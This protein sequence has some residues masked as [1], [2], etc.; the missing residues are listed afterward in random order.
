MDI[1]KSVFGDDYKYVFDG[2]PPTY[3]GF[4][5]NMLMDYLENYLTPTESYPCDE[6]Q[7]VSNAGDVEIY[8]LNSI[9]YEIITWNE[10]AEEHKNG[11]KEISEIII[12]E[13]VE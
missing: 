3:I 5:D 7:T 10:E 8:E 2:D 9:K 13:K 4:G 11:E 12:G 1:N 6:S